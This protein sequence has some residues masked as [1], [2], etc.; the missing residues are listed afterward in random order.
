MNAVTRKKYTRKEILIENLLGCW[1][2][3]KLRSTGSLSKW[4]SSRR[5]QAPWFWQLSWSWLLFSLHVK[6]AMRLYYLHAFLT[7][8]DHSLMCILCWDPMK[9]G[10]HLAMPKYMLASYLAHNWPN[11]NV[12]IWCRYTQM[13]SPYLRRAMSCTWRTARRYH[14]RNFAA[15]R[16]HIALSPMSVV[17]L[18]PHNVKEM[19]CTIKKNPTCI[20]Y[21]AAWL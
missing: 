7:P 19:A 20:I 8:H 10:A 2:E 3:I 21:M 15:A 1:A 14:A 4:P 17:V 9:I 12:L 13:L 11:K 5:K 16:E 6:R 18:R